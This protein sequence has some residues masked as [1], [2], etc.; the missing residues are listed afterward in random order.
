MARI[1]TC[2]AP[3]Y[4][5]DLYF[6]L[7]T[8]PYKTITL[9]VGD[10][11]VDTR[12]ENLKP[13]GKGAY[14]TVCAAEDNV[15]GEGVA[16]KKVGGIFDDLVAAKRILRE[17]RVNILSVHCYGMSLSHGA[18]VHIA[19]QPSCWP[20]QHCGTSGHNDRATL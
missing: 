19:T 16:I 14:G 5:P 20:P 3:S 2:I 12:Y 8:R 15:S 9:K 6:C 18:H 1:T 4:K 11:R 10:F 7:Q 17:I 13:A